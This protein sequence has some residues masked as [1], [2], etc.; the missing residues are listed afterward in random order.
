MMNTNTFYLSRNLDLRVLMIFAES[1]SS[2]RAVGLFRSMMVALLV[3]FCGMINAQEICDNGVDDDGDAL[4]DLNDTADCLCNV[5]NDVTS[6]IPNPSF[7]DYDCVPLMPGMLDCAVT[8]EQATVGTSDYFLNV[9]GGFWIPEIPMPAP[10]GD[11]V[12]GFI[13]CESIEVIDDLGTQDTVA[14][15]EYIG[16][17]LLSPMLAGVEYTLQMEL[18]GASWD[19]ATGAGVFYG[20]LDI[21]IFGSA[22][23]PQWPVIIESDIAFSSPC[24]VVLDSWTELGSVSYTADATWQT[25]TIQFTPATDIEAIMIGG[26]CDMP[27][28]FILNPGGNVVFPYFWVDD[29]VLNTTA[30]FSSIVEEGSLCLDN[31]TLEA[32]PTDD[33]IEAY[34]WYA[35]GIAIQGETDSTL[36]FS[37]LNLQ[38]GFYQVVVSLGDGSCITT[39]VNI[40]L[41]QAEIPELTIEP[42]S[43]CAPLTVEFSHEDAEG[44]TCSWMFGDGAD[45]DECNTEHTYTSEGTFDV[46]LMI[47]DEDGCAGDTTYTNLIEVQGI[48]EAGFTSSPEPASV[49]NTEV[50]FFPASSANITDWLWDF[51]DVPPGSSTEENPVVNFPP[52]PGLYPVELVITVAEGCT[53]T[54]VGFVTVVAAGTPTMPNVF[55]PNGDGDNARFRPFELFPGDWTMIIWNRWGAQVFSTDDIASGWNGDDAAEGTYYWQIEPRGTQSGEALSG[56]VTLVR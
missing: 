48:L 23:C 7:E 30:S 29:L 1:S 19:G 38:P 20:P 3:F 43:G 4:I 34:Q 5:S 28:D 37:D 49:D 54:I 14:Y 41:P 39:G 11:G 18:A 33:D 56:Y 24:P 27:D 9:E 47:I 31:L 12:A 13:A 8:W 26:P 10:D 35:A 2:Q 40:E 17:C 21:T 55:T 50:T 51:G 22:S 6:L 46:T 16:G 52:I 32:N 25:V 36:A 42:S 44:V 15:L 53:R 45:G